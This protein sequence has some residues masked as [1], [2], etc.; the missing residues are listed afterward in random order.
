M[1]CLCLTVTFDE[2]GLVVG[3][4]C[5][6]RHILAFVFLLLFFF[7]LQGPFTKHLFGSLMHMNNHSKN[8][9]FQPFR[10]YNNFGAQLLAIKSMLVKS[11]FFL[12]VLFCFVC[13][14]FLF[15]LFVGCCFFFFLYII[16]TQFSP[17]VIIYIFCLPIFIFNTL[18]GI[19]HQK[20]PFFLHQAPQHMFVD[21]PLM[22][23]FKRMPL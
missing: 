12:F 18:T 5:K 17:F 7:H 1:L 3:E 22:Q 6:F 21:G 11:I 2:R 16:Q 23:Y 14:L 4:I 20:A 8:V 13:L 9:L 19:K 15:C 10:L